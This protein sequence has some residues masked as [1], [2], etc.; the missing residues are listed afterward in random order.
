MAKK[1]EPKF[2]E[3][4]WGGEKLK[5]EFNKNFTENDVGESWELSFAKNYESKIDGNNVTEILTKEDIGKNADGFPFFPMLI[6]FIDA[7]SDLSIQVHPSD[8][9]ALKNEGQYGKTEMWY[10]LSAEEGAGIYFGFKKEPPK[11]KLNELMQTGEICDYLNFFE[12][13]AGET[14]F[15]KSGTV[16][17]IGKGVV[18]Y[19]IQQNSTLTYRLYDFKR[20]DKNGKQRE[21]HT[22]KAAE[23][24]DRTTLKEKAA[25]F[26]SEKGLG[27]TKTPLGVS[28]YFSCFSIELDGK[29]SFAPSKNTF[30]VLSVVDGECVI[31]GI[32]SVKG[33]SIFVSCGEELCLEGCGKL[34]LAKLS[35]FHVG[36][37]LG[38]TFIKGGIVTDD[39]EILVETSVPTEANCGYKKVEENIAA[40]ISS[41]CENCK[42]DISDIKT[43]GMGVP[44]MIDS[45][46]GVVIYSNNLK[47]DMVH[48]TE[49]IKEMLGITLKITNDANAAVLGEVLFGGARGKKNVVML[50]LGTG[51]GGG[52]VIDRKIFEGGKGVGAELGHTIYVKD[53]EK[54]T[55][56][57][58]GCFE[59]YVSATALIRDTKKALKEDPNS[60]MHEAIKT[61][62][63]VNAKLP[64]DYENSD[65]T[66]KAL[67]ANYIRYLSDACIDFANV[68][69]PEVILIGGGISKQGDNLTDRL[70]KNLDEEIFGG[71]NYSR[72]IIKTATL[73]NLAGLMGAAFLE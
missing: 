69:R 11:E 15:V 57:R 70:Q 22:E 40:L 7:K 6:K 64:F 17:A 34:V 18:I 44:G 14:Y 66:A 5:T 21:L 16:H 72:V 26:R 52:I 4:I 36:I 60:K 43:F 29:A 2:V 32:K 53:G 46:K 49:D 58:K 54:C 27:Y 61:L 56:G 20:I 33:D 50:T 35:S 47:W 24:L 63:E 1:L 12:V 59:A 73:G 37:D 41:L 23:V 55:C 51:L 65:E 67:I 10:I 71:S 30:N 38:G 39:G 42:L 3:Y 45:E 68:F 62:D 19:E 9:Y 13:K 8:D 25:T 28:R 31:N 48:I